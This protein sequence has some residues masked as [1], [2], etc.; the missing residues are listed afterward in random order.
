MFCASRLCGAK[1]ASRRRRYSEV[2][3]AAPAPVT[4]SVDDEVVVAAVAQSSAVKGM[5]AAKKQKRSDGLAS[6]KTRRSRPKKSTIKNWEEEVCESTAKLKVGHTGC[7]A[8]EP[9]LR[10]EW[11]DIREKSKN[12]D[13]WN[14]ALS[15]GWIYEKEVGKGFAA[16]QY[17]VRSSSAGGAA[18]RLGLAAAA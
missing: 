3:A 7:W 11:L 2:P 4:S 8:K 9:F 12:S 10:K 6:G 15:K 18:H 5:K 1:P 17:E 13:E 16:N 14:A